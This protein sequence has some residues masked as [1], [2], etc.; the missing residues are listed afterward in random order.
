MRIGVSSG[1][2]I[3]WRGAANERGQLVLPAVPAG[4]LVL[5]RHPAAATAVVWP[6]L[7]E[8]VAL[9]PAAPIIVAVRRKSA[10][11]PNTTP[12]MI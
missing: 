5:L 3:V 1:A 2:D 11:R 4:A 6:P 12:R 8:A 7:P 9:R 10:F